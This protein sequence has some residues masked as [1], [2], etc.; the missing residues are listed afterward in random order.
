MKRLISL[1]ICISAMCCLFTACND[2]LPDDAV[3]NSSEQNEQFD[4]SAVSV[5]DLPT[6]M[7]TADLST[8]DTINLIAELP[9]DNIWL[10]GLS[11]NDDGT[12]VIFRRGNDLYYYDWTWFTPAAKLPEIDMIDIDDDKTDEVVVALYVN[13]NTNVSLE[14]LHVV[15]IDSDKP[16]D[17]C[18]TNEALKKSFEQKFDVRLEVDEKKTSSAASSKKE[19]SSK[20]ASKAWLI[21]NHDDAKYLIFEQKASD[22][23]DGKKPKQYFKCDVTRAVRDNGNMSGLAGYDSNVN[24]TFSKGKVTVALSVAIKFENSNDIMFVCKATAPVTV[25]DGEFKLGTMKFT[26]M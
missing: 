7:L 11:V 9:D 26:K 10:Y 24:Y 20:A 15:D 5:S 6:E 1:L 4:V 17:M 19:S 18:F 8:W 25:R 21:E 3:D 13:H 16:V 2:D 12:G 23:S 14:E 22:V